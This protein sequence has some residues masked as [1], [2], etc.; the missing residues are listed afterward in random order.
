[1]LSMEKNCPY[2]ISA[3]ATD[4][5][6]GLQYLFLPKFHSPFRVTHHNPAC[7]PFQQ[8]HSEVP[9][10]HNDLLNSR[11]RRVPALLVNHFHREHGHG[12]RG[13]AG[14]SQRVGAGHHE[15]E[16]LSIKS[17]AVSVTVHSA[18]GSGCPSLRGAALALRALRGG[19]RELTTRTEAA[20]GL[21]RPQLCVR[22]TL[23]SYMGC[24]RVNNH[25]GRVIGIT[26]IQVSLT[27][28][29]IV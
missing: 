4:I 11:Q 5:S 23:G 25:L 14:L 22:F 19:A 18:S 13:R 20:S 28:I 8:G 26:L 15:A 3:Y 10:V 17:A 27:R 9:H 6:N 21:I 7:F 1:M 12:L 2:N 24:D 29:V 16:H